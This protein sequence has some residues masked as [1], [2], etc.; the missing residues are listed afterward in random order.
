[1]TGED[2]K[3]QEQQ[4]EEDKA[5]RWLKVIDT[6]DREFKRWHTRCEKILKIYTERRRTEG[7]E[8][9]RMSL[10]WSNISVLQPA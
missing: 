4:D 3:T 2:D 1:M 5:R 6:Y 9:R 10:L 8:V 7:T